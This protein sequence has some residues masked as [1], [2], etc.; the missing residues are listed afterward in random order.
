MKTI[1]YD[2]FVNFM[3]WSLTPVFTPF[4]CVS[5][6]SRVCWQAPDYQTCTIRDEFCRNV[7]PEK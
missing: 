7:L 6:Q 4:G 1:Q 3:K 5:Q 2:D